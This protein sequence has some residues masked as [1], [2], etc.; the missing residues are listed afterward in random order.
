[1]PV[2]GTQLIT[3]P[4]VPCD[5]C[6]IALRIYRRALQWPLHMGLQLKSRGWGH[7]TY[8]YIRV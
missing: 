8:V 1:M 7:S 5:T 6:A 2:L 4:L 3:R